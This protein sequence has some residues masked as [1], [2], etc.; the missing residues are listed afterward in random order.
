MQ[1]HL[2]RAAIE[3]AAIHSPLSFSP[4]RVSDGARGRSGAAAE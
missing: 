2:P 1:A 3:A 4:K